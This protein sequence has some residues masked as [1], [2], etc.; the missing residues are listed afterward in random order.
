MPAAGDGISASTLSVE[1]SKIGSS[2]LT[3]SP[4]FLIHSMIVPSAIDSPIWGMTTLTGMAF[5][6][7]IAHA[8][9]GGAVRGV[10]RF[11]HG[12]GHGRMGVDRAHQLLDRALEPQRQRRLGDQL[13]RARADHVDAE[14]LVVLLLGDDLDEAVGLVGHAGAAEDAEG[15]LPRP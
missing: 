9:I 7:L 6:G 15:E 2:R 3:W 4:T 13:G 1:I 12:L 14:H 8:W 5:S 10:R 11:E